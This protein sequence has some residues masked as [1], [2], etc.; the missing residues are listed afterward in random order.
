MTP[1]ESTMDGRVCLVTGANGGMGKV[2]VTDLARRGATVVLVCR[3]CRKGGR[4]TR[5]R[6]GH[7][8]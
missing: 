1:A 7:R 3:D 4:A 2:V 6:R 5:D 8:Q